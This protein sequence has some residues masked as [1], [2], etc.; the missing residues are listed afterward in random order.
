MAD[1]P[2]WR[3][4]STISSSE[5]GSTASGS[6][7][8]PSSTIVTVRPAAVSRAAVVD[9]PAPDPT[10]RTSVCSEVMSSRA[11]NDGRRPGSSCSANRT[12]ERNTRT[13]WRNCGIGLESRACTLG[14]PPPRS[15]EIPPRPTEAATSA[16]RRCSGIDRSAP[17]TKPATPAVARDPSSSSAQQRLAARTGARTEVSEPRYYPLQPM[18]AAVEVP[19]RST[20]RPRHPIVAVAAMAADRH[21]RRGRPAAAAGAHAGARAAHGRGLHARL[22]RGGAPRRDPEPGLPAPVRARAACGCSPPCSRCSR[23]RC[24]PSGSPATSSRSRSIA[25]VYVMVRPYGRRLAVGGAA[26]AAIIIIPPIGLT[27]LAWVGGVALGLWAMVAALRGRF[28]LAGVLGGFALLFRPDLVARGGSR[29]RRAVARARSGTTASGCS[30]GSASAS[31]RTSI[32]IAMAG[33]GPRVLRHGDPAGLPAAVRPAP[34]VAAVVEP[35]RRLPAEG[36]RAQRAA[37]AV[38]VAAVA[39]PAHPVARCLLVAAVVTMVARGLAGR[40]AL[41]RARWPGGRCSSWACSASACCRRRCSGPIPPISRGSSAV[42][43]RAA[44]G[45]DRGT[46]TRQLRPHWSTARAG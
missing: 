30:A 37:V 8:G 39:R 31:A 12:S 35:L 16:A 27:A 24:G 13:Y 10:T 5:N 28:L 15:S 43:V 3:Y 17:S 7:H 20:R 42:P 2:R 29:F 26:I 11:R 9:P 44:P 21:R 22:P 6:I 45:R 34:A 18:S 36:R 14:R 40:P 25:A 1:D 19:A 33:P 32:H 38:P 46:R 23:R 41:A 4:F